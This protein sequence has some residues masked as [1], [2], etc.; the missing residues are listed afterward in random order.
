MPCPDPCDA[1]FLT[2]EGLSLFV[3]ARPGAKRLRAPRLVD[4]GEG[5][6]ALEIS[7]QEGAVDGHANNALIKTTAKGL[8]VRR[9]D[10]VIKSGAGGRLKR[11]EVSGVPEEIE[12]SL[13]AWITSPS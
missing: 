1:F 12:K 4:V 5:K 11:L 2:R 7:V 3:K 6:T 9:Q 8:G 13:R 10:I